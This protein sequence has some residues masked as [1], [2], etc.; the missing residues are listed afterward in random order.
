MN[1]L[2]DLKNPHLFYFPRIEEA[3]SF[4][5]EE[6]SKHCARVLR[7]KEGD[8]IILM[9]G[10]GSFYKASISSAN[11][12]KCAFLVLD[13]NTPP[14]ERNFYL[15][16]AVAPTKNIERFEWFLEKATEMGIDEIT[17]LICRNSERRELKTARLQRVLISAMKQSMHS[18]LPVLNECL[19]LPELLKKDT[20]A[21]ARYIAH[22]RDGNKELLKNVYPPGKNVLIL[23]GPEGDFTAEEVNDAIQKQFG[24]VSLGNSRLRTETA[25]L[26][27]CFAI[28]LINS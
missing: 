9:D 16:M 25:A 20:S 21:Y 15:H 10:L 2:W 23:I 19:S 5:D 11:P 17:P 1:N 14:P 22:C 3:E 6:E 4:L 12:K 8:V 26:A 27:G 13:K 18:R 7:L 28:N 24:P